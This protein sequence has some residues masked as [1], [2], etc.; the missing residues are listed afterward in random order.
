LSQLAQLVT[1]GVPFIARPCQGAHGSENLAYD[2][3]A[4]R[5]RQ[6][7]SILQRPVG[8][9]SHASA[10]ATPESAT[11]VDVHSRFEA[12]GAML[13][14]MLL[15]GQGLF[16]VETVQGQM[17]T[18]RLRHGINRRYVRDLQALQRL[19]IEH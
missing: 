13:R 17:L 3:Q 2:E 11:A 10:F 14:R 1:L 18:Q 9:R 5:N 19:D 15:A 7:C 8:F 16:N 4:R 6:A 12:I